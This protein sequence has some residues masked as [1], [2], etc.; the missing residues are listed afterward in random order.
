MADIRRQTE[1]PIVLGGIG[2]S[3][4]PCKILEYSGADYGI[5]GEGEFSFPE[6]VRKLAD[7][8]DCSDIPGLVYKSGKDIVLNPQSFPGLDLLSDCRR[9]LID[10][11]RYYREGGMGSIETKRGC[12][13]NCM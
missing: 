6:L 1:A 2:F 8:E 3:I 9:E 5:K 13:E 12:A 11:E 4:M 7:G 10:N